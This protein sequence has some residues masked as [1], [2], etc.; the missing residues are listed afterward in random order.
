MYVD[1]SVSDV[2]LLSL[3]TRSGDLTRAAALRQ[4]I[5]SRGMYTCL[6]NKEIKTFDKTLQRLGGIDNIFNADAFRSKHLTHLRLLEYTYLENNGMK[7][8][9]KS[10][11]INMT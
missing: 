3:M 4:N 6:G 2:T 9:I 8:K 10:R 5:E 1:E 11:G 7:S